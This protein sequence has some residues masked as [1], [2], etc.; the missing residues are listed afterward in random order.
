MHCKQVQILLPDWVQNKET[1][2]TDEFFHHLEACSTCNNE[3][4]EMKQLFA[5]IENDSLLLPNEQYFVNLL[6]RIHQRIEKGPA[7]TVQ[8][9]R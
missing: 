1:Q 6:P 7:C 4:K 3:A 5:Q 2:M 8:R 9:R